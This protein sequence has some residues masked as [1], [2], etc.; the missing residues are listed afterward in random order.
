MNRGRV[1]SLEQK[2]KKKKEK[3]IIQVHLNDYIFKLT[4]PTLFKFTELPETFQMQIWSKS[5]FTNSTHPIK[6][7]QLQLNTAEVGS[8]E[9]QHFSISNCSWICPKNKRKC[10]KVIWFIG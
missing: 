10:H 5:P 8:I 7:V 6:R 9:Q 3:D 1:V 2:K 4:V